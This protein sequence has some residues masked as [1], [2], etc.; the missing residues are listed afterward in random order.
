MHII[1]LPMT[2]TMR[3]PT[4]THQ[5]GAVKFSEAAR[6]GRMR[7]VKIFLPLAL[8]LFVS[9]TA[10][11][12]TQPAAQKAFADGQALFAGKHPAEAAEK[13]EVVVA[14]EPA[15]A[16]GW[17]ALAGARRRAGQCDRAIPAYRRY[18]ALQP[19]ETE[20]YYGL[21][22]CLKAVD[23]RKAAIEALTRYVNEEKRP[24]TQR[25]V[26][27]ARGVLAELAEEKPAGKSAAPSPAASPPPGPTAAARAPATPP[28]LSPPPPETPSL[29]GSPDSGT[30][31]AAAAY[32]E[33]QSLRDR[34]HIEE[35]IGKFRQ[36]ISA[37]PSHMAS[38]AALGEL[39]IKVRRDDEAITVFRGAV[40][41]NPSYALAWYELA[42]ALRVRGRMQEAVEAYKRYIKLRPADPDPYFGLGR[43]LQKLGRTQEAVHAYETYVGMEKRPSEDRWVKQATAELHTL[44]AGGAGAH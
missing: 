18:A 20:P 2:S 15:F 42:F 25:F 44:S 31:P 5:I 41:K 14:A 11:A 16:P 10:S 22:L 21:G 29:T 4:F 38:R 9:A 30:N 19:R 40:E 23:D 8:C 12:Q 13:F 43:A 32:N 28:S 36:A 37:D 7:V 17:Y 39:L 3:F 1:R 35:A 27:H 24:E 26:E 33:A 34:G 6:A